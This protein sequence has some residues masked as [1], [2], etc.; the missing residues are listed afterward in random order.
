[1][2]LVHCHLAKQPLEINSLV[3]EKI[4]P[5]VEAIIRKLMAKT[6][7][8]RYQSAYGIRADLEECL[9]QLETTGKIEDFVIARQD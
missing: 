4:P 8:E 1:L 7:E 5:V 6:P 2:E 9:R 3:R